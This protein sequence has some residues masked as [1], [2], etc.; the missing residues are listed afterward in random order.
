MDERH[1]E[2]AELLRA[3]LERGVRDP[4]AFR[5][6][7]LEVPPA[8]RD[9][10]LD[11]VLGLSEISADSA[12]LPRECVPY[13]PCSV[14]A[15]LR[16]VERADIG[17]SDVFVDVGA[18]VGRASAFVHLLTGAGAIG[19]EVQHGLVTTARDLAKRLGLKRVSTVEGDAIDLVGAMTF[20]SVFFF[21]CPFSGARLTRVMTDLEA[22]ARARP[23]R[24]C[25][26][27]LPLPPHAW[28]DPDPRG[29]DNV[30]VHRSKTPAG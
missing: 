29:S 21:Y 12:D 27:D 9:G 18:G 11:H 22:I 15:L 6:A 30:A 14:D 26:V 10:W 24:V 17:P 8:A 28:L 4:R 2:S 3:E 25:C 5:A 13:L 20:G 7:L 23:I 19:I 16:V 1:R